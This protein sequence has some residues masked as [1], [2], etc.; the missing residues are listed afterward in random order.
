[1]NLFAYAS[2]F[3]D[4]CSMEFIKEHLNSPIHPNVQMFSANDMT[5]ACQI[6]LNI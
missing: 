1:M 4:N 6:A 5:T 3:F 2:V